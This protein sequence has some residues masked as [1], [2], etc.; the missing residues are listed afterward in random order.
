MLSAPAV[1]IE[2]R[3][4]SAAKGFDAAAAAGTKA[5]T[6]YLYAARS[7]RAAGSFA[8]A[9]PRFQKVVSA[10]GTSSD[11][12]WAAIEGG[13]CARQMGDVATARVLFGFAI[14]CL[15]LLV[16]DVLLLVGV[17]GMRAVRDQSDEGQTP[18]ESGD[19]AGN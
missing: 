5:S 18:G 7:H 2:G 6:S 13:D 10:Y 19:D 14:A 17:L 3:Y 15:V 9:M 1:R 12:P 16:V 8:L 11:A 4:A